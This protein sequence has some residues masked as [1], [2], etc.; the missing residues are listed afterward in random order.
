MSQEQASQQTPKVASAVS[1]KQ[2]TRNYCD[3]N[4]WTPSKGQL[5]EPVCHAY[6]EQVLETYKK[7]AGAKSTCNASGNIGVG[8][9]VHPI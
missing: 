3:K 5:G 7:Y 1:T 2:A 9:P 8:T 6:P 4:L